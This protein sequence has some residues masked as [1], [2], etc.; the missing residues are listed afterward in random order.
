[1]FLN[2][3]RK[4]IEKNVTLIL[5]KNYKF[6]DYLYPTNY[7]NS[8]TWMYR[9][10]SILCPL[11]TLF[12]S[13]QRLPY[14]YWLVCKWFQ[15]KHRQMSLCSSTILLKFQFPGQ[16]PCIILRTAFQKYFITKT[17]NVFYL[18]RKRN[19]GSC[20]LQLD[21]IFLNISDRSS[22]SAKNVL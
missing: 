9:I 1:M 4:Q 16:G 11:Y 12:H 13:I 15:H 18:T 22:I 17:D 5:I 19:L 10:P 7:N 2:S 21:C 20:F 8:T 6:Y 14:K 3:G